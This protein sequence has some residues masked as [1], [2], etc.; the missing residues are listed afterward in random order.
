MIRNKSARRVVTLGLIGVGGVLMLLAPPVWFGLIP[1]T[2][3]LL[4]EV[5]GITLEHTERKRR[6][7]RL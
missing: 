7:H 4:L 3:G 6:P 2:L 1:L 5:V